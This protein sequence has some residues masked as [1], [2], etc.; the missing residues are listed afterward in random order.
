MTI[1]SITVGARPA[2]TTVAPYVGLRP[3]ERNEADIFYGRGEHIAEMLRVLRKQHFLAVVG[4]SGSGKSS[5]VRAGLL[6]AIAAGSR[7]FDPS[8]APPL[9]PL[10]WIQ[11]RKPVPMLAPKI[12]SPLL[13]LTRFLHQNPA[14]GLLQKV[15]GLRSGTCV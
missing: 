13:L 3:F 14:F 9:P 10:T 6:P 11:N 2:S 8:D 12:S 15:S 1:G 4:S 5:L 7:A